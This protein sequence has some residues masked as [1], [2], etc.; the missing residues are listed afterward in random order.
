MRF[1]T[2]ISWTER[3]LWN[4]HGPLSQSWQQGPVI[5]HIQDRINS[6]NKRWKE[7]FPLNYKI[8]SEK[9]PS[10]LLFCCHLFPKTHKHI[11]NCPWTKYDSSACGAAGNR[12]VHSSSY[13]VSHGSYRQLCSYEVLLP[14]VHCAPSWEEWVLTEEFR[15]AHKHVQVS[16]TTESH[17]SLHS[18]ETSTGLLS[19]AQQQQNYSPLPPCHLLKSL[20]YGRICLKEWVFF[21]MSTKTD[22]LL[23]THYKYP[24]STSAGDLKSKACIG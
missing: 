18:S 19:P 15:R 5:Q 1:H 6:K 9:Y 16:R 20:P 10:V 7:K 17:A 3:H 13:W 24:H 14:T 21:C 2:V 8:V 4:H 23:R 22:S 11:P 12:A